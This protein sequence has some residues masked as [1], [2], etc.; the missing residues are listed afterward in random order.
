MIF[1]QFTNRS[2]EE[3]K[4][5]WVKHYNDPNQNSFSNAIKVDQ[6]GNI[7]VIGQS[8]MHDY[9]TIKY[10]SQGNETWQTKFIG[11][12]NDIARKV[13]IDEYG[14]CYVV[15]SST[16]YPNYNDSF[17]TVKYNSDGVEQW[18]TYTS[19][20]GSIPSV[21]KCDK[22][23]NIY[24]TGYEHSNNGIV[25]LKLDSLGNEKWIAKYGESLDQSVDMEI[26]FDNSVYICGHANISNIANDSDWII[27]KYDT[28]GKIVWMD[29]YDSG[30][31]YRDKATSLI[32]DKEGYLYVGGFVSFD[33]NSI[34]RKW[35]I[36]KYDSFGNRIWIKYY[37][38]TNKW[39]GNLQIN[40]ICIASNGNLIV[41]GHANAISGTSCT[42]ILCNSDSDILWQRHLDNYSGLSMKLNQNDDI[43]ISMGGFT[44]VKYTLL[45]DHVWTISHRESGWE[46]GPSFFDIYE[47]GS[48]FITGRMTQFVNSKITY[49]RL[50]TVKFL[51]DIED[52][53]TNSQ[54]F[55]Y[56]LFQNYP[57]PFNS[58]TKITYNIPDIAF[59]SLKVFDL[60]GNEIKTLIN[61]RASPGKYEINFDAK[62]LSSG[63]YFYRLNAGDFCTVNKMLIIK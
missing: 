55:S 35:A 27:I 56:K 54:V 40:D 49:S 52:Q 8:S 28:E 15:G 50:V 6:H 62:E 12:N 57:N 31:N 5:E 30:N 41:T 1:L 58:E 20:Y 47:D 23:G 51:E 37:R 43:F 36:I 17:M 32:L 14:N 60:K 2:F 10:D 4:K 63:L 53:I 45:G 26:S 24:I 16:S 18:H 25:T 48:V 21:I 39:N 22:L 61:E 7:F 3:I 19:T 46:N 29:S 38:P 13:A 9:L 42:T 33:S 59:V 44:I 11:N 34:D